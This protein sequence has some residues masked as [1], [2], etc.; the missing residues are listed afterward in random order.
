MFQYMLKNSERKWDLKQKHC[1]IHLSAGRKTSCWAEAARESFVRSSPSGRPVSLR[2]IL[3]FTRP[4]S[5]PHFPSVDK[6]LRIPVLSQP[7]YFWRLPFNK[8]HATNK[9]ASAVSPGRITSI[10]EMRSCIF[11]PLASWVVSGQKVARQKSSKESESL[12]RKRTSVCSERTQRGGRMGLAVWSQPGALHSP[13]PWSPPGICFYKAPGLADEMEIWTDNFVYKPQTGSPC[14]SAVSSPPDF[15]TLL[16][17]DFC[18]AGCGQNPGALWGAHPFE[19][20]PQS[21]S[22]EWPWQIGLCIVRPWRWA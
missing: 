17:Q 11:E 6:R 15:P 8:I 4:F 20:V 2:V 19:T 22:M 3:L 21:P 10:S 12:G 1:F 9:K 16:H 13:Q 14:L 18:T 5:E 7:P